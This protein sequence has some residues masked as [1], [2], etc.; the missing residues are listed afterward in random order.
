MQSRPNHPNYSQLGFR[1][2]PPNPLQGGLSCSLLPFA[3]LQKMCVSQQPELRWITVGLWVLAAC[4]GRSTRSKQGFPTNT[5]PFAP[6]QGC[7]KA[8]ESRA[9]FRKKRVL[10]LDGGQ[11]RGRAGAGQGQGSAGQGRAARRPLNKTPG[12]LESASCPKKREQNLFR[13]IAGLDG[14]EEDNR[15]RLAVA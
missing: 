11:G 5:W 9:T 10:G 1:A 8:R 7:S 14:P 15:K 13:T 6:C 4:A 2:H 3:A 12:R